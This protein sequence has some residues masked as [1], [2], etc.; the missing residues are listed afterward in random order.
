M[1]QAFFL[2]FQ[3]M[4]TT[5]YNMDKGFLGKILHQTAISDNPLGNNFPFLWKTATQLS[6]KS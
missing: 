1:K 2:V 5:L 3:Q 4:K 6:P